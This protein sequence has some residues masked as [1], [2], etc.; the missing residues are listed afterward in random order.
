[1]CTFAWACSLGIIKSY[2]F[3]C[4]AYIENCVYIMLY[5]YINIIYTYII[6]VYNVGDKRSRIRRILVSVYLLYTEFQPTVLQVEISIL[7]IVNIY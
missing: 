6:N 2:M 5:I 4:C 3:S 1:M 7:C